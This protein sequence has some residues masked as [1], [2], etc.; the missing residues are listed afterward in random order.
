MKAAD[1]AGPAGEW[2][3]AGAAARPEVRG[4]LD[5]VQIA[6]G[7]G[8]HWRPWHGEDDDRAVVRAPACGDGRDR[9]ATMGS[10]RPTPADGR[11]C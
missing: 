2:E 1:A 8:A 10:A 4:S 6:A 11:A 7:V 9:R 5:D 3:A